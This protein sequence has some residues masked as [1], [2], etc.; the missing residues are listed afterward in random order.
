MNELETEILQ[1]EGQVVESFSDVGTAAVKVVSNSTSSFIHWIQSFLTWNNLAIAIGAI[2]MLIVFCI[3]YIILKHSVKR[4]PSEK[5]PPN[6]AKVIL[7][8]L[9]YVFYAA[10]IM[11][12]L[13]IFGIRLSA[14]WGAAGVAGVA[15]A[16]AAQTSF[17]NLISG[18][19]ILA[20]RTLQIGDLI[21]ASGETGIVDSVGLLSVKIHTLDNQ[22]IRIPNSSIINSTLRNTTYFPKRRFDITV[23]VAYDTDM[24]AAL[25][26]LNKAP[27]LCP[28]VLQDPAPAA[29]FN[30]FES[31]GI[32]MTLAVWFKSDDFLAT[33]N[34]A[35]IAI[36]K[37]FDEA[38]IEIPYTK[39]DI[40]LA[41]GASMPAPAS[42]PKAVKAEK[43]VKAPKTAKAAKK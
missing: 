5:L 27:S 3:I 17:S 35:F 21:T 20:E 22:M 13:S 7:K 1:A 4:I 40:N 38:K 15:V 31:S 24:T 43:T 2:F 16:F 18:V 34:A 26:T 25:E 19:F 14:I 23:E 10:I 42:K 6:K 37:V 32:S 8:F 12:I 33:K 29:W 9:K 39:I 28:T 30:G 41:D 11:Y 36:K